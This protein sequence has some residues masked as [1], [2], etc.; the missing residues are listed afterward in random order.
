M[1]G[2]KSDKKGFAIL[3]IA[4]FLILIIFMMLQ[5]KPVLVDMVK[6]EYAPMKV[7]LDEEGKTRVIDRFVI[8]A[9]IDAFMRRIR[10]NEGDK[11][12]KGQTLL[13]L[14]PVP[15]SV[16]DP[17][18]RAQAEASLG[19]TEELEKVINEMSEAA[20][21][22]KV[23]AGITF[24]RTNEL[25][26]NNVVAENEMDIVKA[27]KRR[28][29]AVYR[30]SQF[31]KVLTQYLTQMSRSALNYEDVRQTDN[32]VR[33]FIVSSAADGM[34]LNLSGKSERVVKMGEVL[35]ELGDIVQLEIE[36]DV[37]STMA[38]K[39]K[40]NM[41]VEIIRWGGEQVL[42]GL[43]KRI[44]PSGFT[45]YS[46]LGVE[47]Q[48]VKVIAS[49]NTGL[50]TESGLKDGFRV[51]TRFVL[52]QSDK[53]LQ[54]PNSALFKSKELSNHSTNNEWFVY[55]I[56]ENHLQKRAVKTGQKNNLMT[57][58]ISGLKE[59][60]PVVSYLSNDLKEGTSV[61]IRK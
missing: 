46:A 8:T 4:V 49:I 61:E 42:Q 51:E 30:A 26:K 35:M 27:E 10:F 58:I 9:P 43:I 37:L 60:D 14:E 54:I 59:N 55:L 40:Q 36:S 50:T 13:T 22:D 28:A 33:H 17:R 12:Q 16:L 39:L 48:R 29:E 57:E 47:E 2:K 20:K 34:I 32:D 6:A 5:E 24:H 18:S 45:K 23:L 1:S 44:E 21:A 38:V 53:V 7:T 11:V 52:W 41:P 31:A 56:S 25:R 3:F 15:S 19:A